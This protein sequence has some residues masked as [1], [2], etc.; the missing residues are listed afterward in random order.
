MIA[1]VFNLQSY[2]WNVWAVPQLVSSIFFCSLGAFVLLQNKSSK[3]NIFFSLVCF[4]TCLWFFGLFMAF[5]CN[6]ASTAFFWLRLVYGSIIFIP[7][8]FCH[9]VINLFPGLVTMRGKFFMRIIPVIHVLNLFLLA[10]LLLTDYYITPQWFP[11]GWYGKV[12]IFEPLFLVTLVFISMAS[13]IFLYFGQRNASFPV[14]K[15]RH[16]R[17]LLCAIGIYVLSSVD[18]LPTFG[19][20]IYPFG[21]IFNA[22]FIAIVAFTIVRYHLMEIDTVVHRTLL[23]GAT[24]IFLL[25]PP[26]YLFLVVLE[27]IRTLK[28]PFM[29]HP[30]IAAVLLLMFHYYY[31]NLRPKIDHLFR[32]RRYDY[33]QILSRLALSLKGILDMEQISSE[34]ANALKQ[35]VYLTK[36][37]IIAKD[38]QT[39]AFITLKEEGFQENIPA[40][41]PDDVFVAYMSTHTH[42]ETDLIEVDPTLTVLK[43]SSLYSY[44]TKEGILVVLSLALE[45]EFIGMLLLGKRE[46]LQQYT[47]RDIKILEDIALDVSLYFYNALHHEDILEKQRLQQEILLAK[48]IQENLLPQKAPVVDGL[49]LCGRY[50]PSKEIGGD[51]YDFLTASASAIQGNGALYVSIGDVSGKG[52]DAGLVVSSVK[53]SLAALIEFLS[54]PKDILVRLNRILFDE[55]REKKFVSLLLFKYDPVQKALSYSS[56]GHE[57]ILVW[58]DR[59]VEIVK[60]GGVILG[61]LEDIEGFLEESDFHLQVGDKVLLYTD[62]ATEARN[63]HEELY[64]LERLSDSLVR[65]GNLPITKVRNF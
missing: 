17:Y 40:I 6:L 64:G 29:V 35:E 3:V 7:I 28:V 59:K 8:C 41:V 12:Q 38:I 33:S 46:N 30:L 22:T 14:A 15:R 27:K 16:M 34:V 24:L 48:N 61:M 39:G 47:L 62:G 9:F 2:S 50:Q 58:H 1:E 10:A 25:L 54:S 63:P 13:L 55:I 43:Q 4:C 21:F 20:D 45:N 49:V 5:M 57:R 65:Y 53:S 44:I 60:S 26:G 31:F 32:R 36:V 51:Y 37:A 56:C 18:F 19:I 52:L 11:W 42:L 23:W